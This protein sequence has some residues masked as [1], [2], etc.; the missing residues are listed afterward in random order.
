MLLCVDAVEGIMCVTDK[1]VKAALAEGM[2]ICLLITK[3][4]PPPPF[5]PSS[6]SAFLILASAS[7]YPGMSAH[8]GDPK[9]IRT[10]R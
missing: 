7:S 10:Q 6:S 9:L 5:F 3:V 4:A 8:R 1:A 2:P